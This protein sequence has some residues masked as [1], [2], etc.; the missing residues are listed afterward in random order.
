MARFSDSVCRR[1]ILI[2]SPGRRLCEDDVVDSDDGG[3]P[4]TRGEFAPRDVDDDDAEE[5]LELLLLLRR[6]LELVEAMLS[7][8]DRTFRTCLDGRP[9]EIDKDVV[10]GGGTG[11]RILCRVVAPLPE[12]GC[13]VMLC[14]PDIPGGVNADA[15]AREDKT[16]N[17]TVVRVR[18]TLECMY[19]V[20]DD[21]DD[22]CDGPELA[23]V[24]D[25]CWWSPGR[26]RRILCRR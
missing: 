18:A 2:F 11:S 3:E 14:R 12:K 9:G 20:L 4:L 15:R 1:W 23:F 6:S 19:W 7:G 8:S 25:V 21:D 26:F 13:V 24:T 10:L 16:H 17:A 22:N 5:E